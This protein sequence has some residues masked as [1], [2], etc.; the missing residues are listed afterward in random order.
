M[1]A[2]PHTKG[3]KTKLAGRA[4]LVRVNKSKLQL[5]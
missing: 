3:K 4:Y 5:H 2:D 1:E